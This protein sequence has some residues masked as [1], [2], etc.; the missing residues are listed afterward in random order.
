MQL[1]GE[2]NQSPMEMFMMGMVKCESPGVREWIEQQ[3]EGI[4][5]L[6]NYRVAWEDLEDDVAHNLE[7]DRHDQGPFQINN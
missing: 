2:M 6:P 1:K 4:E 7:Q 3:E 5:D